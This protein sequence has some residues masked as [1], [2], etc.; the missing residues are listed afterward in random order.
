MGAETGQL[1]QQP[2]SNW[3]QKSPLLPPYPHSFF[4]AFQHLLPDFEK[5]LMGGK[6]G[7]MQYILSANH[8]SGR[9]KQLKEAV[10][11]RLLIRQLTLFFQQMHELQF[12]PPVYT[13]PVSGVF[14][15]LH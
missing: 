2:S 8:P 10:F 6:D 11:S 13:S 9:R 4:Q 15:G 5:D 3:A 14:N 7:G 1:Q 12:P